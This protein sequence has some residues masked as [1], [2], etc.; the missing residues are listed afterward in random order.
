ME[1]VQAHFDSW[2]G[3]GH[4]F[5][6]YE[7]AKIEARTLAARSSDYEYPFLLA[8][9]TELKDV[10]VPEAPPLYRKQRARRIVRS[11]SS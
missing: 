6:R 4:P 7:D 8:S 3:M 11:S 5:R 9:Q 10:G 2:L 1:I